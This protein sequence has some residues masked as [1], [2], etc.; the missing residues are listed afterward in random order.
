MGGININENFAVGYSYDYSVGNTTFKY[1]GGS[2]EI[3]LR[4]D[5][6]IQEERCC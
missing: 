3:L 5:F 2:H 6:Y 1:N 4:Y